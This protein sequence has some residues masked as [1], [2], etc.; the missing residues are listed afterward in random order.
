MIFRAP[1]TLR[2]GAL[3]QATLLFILTAVCTLAIYRHASAAVPLLV[4][5][6]RD[7]FVD[8]PSAPPRVL[9]EDPWVVAGQDLQAGGTWLGVNECGMVV[10]LLNRRN[11]KGPDASRRSRGLLC[12]EALQLR[13]VDEVRAHLRHESGRQYNWFNLLVAD[14]DR[15]FVGSNADDRISVSE[16]STGLHLL[17]NL[18]VNDPA[19]PRIAASHRFFA[20]VP[21]PDTEED[22]PALLS[23][24]RGILGNHEIPL[25]PRAGR[26]AE[27]LCVHLPG[28]GTRSST[29]VAL[30]ARTQRLRYWST[31]GPPCMANFQE[32]SLPHAR[33]AS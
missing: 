30:S 10:G 9:A 25:D 18:N 6:N 12:L 31:D 26:D 20:A 32:V 1:R 4:A 23:R 13:S 7:E 28:Y 33:A 24:L 21:L 8:R 29:V 15:A 16:L 5:A 11:P 3:P 17:T 2:A 14:R 19:C 27:T 22:V